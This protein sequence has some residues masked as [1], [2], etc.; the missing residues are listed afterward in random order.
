MDQ[1]AG[2]KI[3]NPDADCQINYVIVIGDGA[4]ALGCSVISRVC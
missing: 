2:G 4:M 3:L 1:D